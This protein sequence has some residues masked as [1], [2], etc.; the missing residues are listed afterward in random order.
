MVRIA[1]NKQAELGEKKIDKQ[2][3]ENSKIHRAGR[4]KYYQRRL[5][6]NVLKKVES[7]LL[8]LNK[9]LNWNLKDW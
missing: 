6:K 1:Q 8:R 7:N 5:R 4:G 9:P 2:I 3:W